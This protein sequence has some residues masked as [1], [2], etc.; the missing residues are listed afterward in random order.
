M[1]QA[2]SYI[3]FN[4]TLSAI[5]ETNIVNIA[6]S[7]KI[8]CAQR[9]INQQ[10]LSKMTGVSEVTIS[11]IINKKGN[12]RHSTLEAFAQAFG[13]PVSEFIALGE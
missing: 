3:K 10:E 9:E 11:G 13:M 5:K 1:T 8:A 2:N 4:N 6:K 7:I 12:C